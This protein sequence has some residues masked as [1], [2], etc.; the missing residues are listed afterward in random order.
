MWPGHGDLDSRTDFMTHFDAAFQQAFPPT[1]IVADIKSCPEDFVVDEVMDIAFSR[2]G[3]HNWVRFRKT[4]CNTDWLASRI[5]NFCGVRRQA[6]SYAGLK[7]RHAVTS[8]WFSVHLPGQPDPDW[9]QFVLQFNDNND[10]ESIALLESVRHTKKLQR[11]AL[12]GNRFVIVFRNMQ[13]CNGHE[14]NVPLETVLTDR[15]RLIAQHGVPNYFGEQRF[16]RDRNNLDSA[17]RM[18]KGKLRRLSR[19]KRSM[20]L[21]AARSWLFNE[22]LAERVRQNNWD[23]RLPGDVFMLNA[24]TACFA[25]DG[26]IGLLESRLEAGEIHPAIVLW[27]EHDELVYADAARLEQKVIEQYPVF[28]QGLVDARIDAS[29]RAARVIPEDVHCQAVEAGFQIGFSLPS[30]CFATTVLKEIIAIN[31]RSLTQKP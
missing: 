30:G 20:Y 21:S 24:R 2:D 17:M 8:Q 5:A 27:G 4:G 22:I 25:D 13:W 26:D 10:N 19:Q 12:R 14:Q 16:G 9:Q 3:E 31:D 29:R 28:R 11:G 18:F 7:D 15:C 1:F 23:R 6:V